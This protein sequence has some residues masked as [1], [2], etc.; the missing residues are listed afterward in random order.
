MK[1]FI[2]TAFTV[3]LSLLSGYAQRLDFSLFD[4][5]KSRVNPALGVSNYAVGN[6]IYRNQ[7]M[8]P[9]FNVNAVGAGYSHPF[10]LRKKP[11]GSV[12]FN[13]IND[14]TAGDGALSNQEYQL[15]LGTGLTL[16][17]KSYVS[18]ALSGTSHIQ[19]LN[20]KNIVTGSQYIDG[21]GF[22]RDLPINEPGLDFSKTFFGIGAGFAY[23]LYD[24]KEDIILQVGLSG[25]DLNSPDASWMEQ[26]YSYPST[27]SLYAKYRAFKNRDWAI[28]PQILISNQ[29]GNTRAQIGGEVSRSL[30]H[31]RL[32]GNMYNAK[33]VAGLAYS[34]SYGPH[35]RI[36]LDWNKW[37]VR[38]GQDIPIEGATNAVNSATEISLVY[39]RQVQKLSHLKWKDRKKRKSRPKTGKKHRA[40]AQL[41]PVKKTADT[42]N[43]T[44]T[45]TENKER[46]SAEPKIEKPEITP[47]TKLPKAGTP[48]EKR[49]LA[50]IRFSFDESDLNDEGRMNSIKALV[51]LMGKTG[52]ITLIGHTDNIGE[53]EYN[54][55]LGLERAKAVKIIF[56]QL[57]ISPDRIST[58]SKGETEPLKPNDSPEN[59]YTNRRVEVMIQ[60]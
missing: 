20:P 50:N 16:T 56:Q 55:K 31:L 11:F 41:K 58:E 15:F 25:H 36:G 13:V 19:K 60:D 53:A 57:G 45:E 28:Y 4:Q 42:S 21:F 9:G 48:P 7:S 59:R 26:D 10:L 39:R 51:S 1:K 44:E 32:P 23:T 27:T 34:T 12:G 47:E 14:R 33:A 37:S 38:V 49:L 22:G 17:K 43:T 52:K 35:A 29:A 3:I 5:N 8:T 2:L 54:H 46:Q 40:R 18:F 6:L 24:K 30:R